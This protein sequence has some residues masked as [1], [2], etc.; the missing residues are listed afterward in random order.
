[1]RYMLINSVSEPRGCYP[2]YVVFFSCNVIDLYL[3]YPSA[4]LNYSITCRYYNHYGWDVSWVS[5]SVR[6]NMLTLSSF[7]SQFYVVI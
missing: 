6:I 3:I 2:M 4:D 7:N 5:T 1:M